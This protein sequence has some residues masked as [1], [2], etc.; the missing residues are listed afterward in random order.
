MT[1]RWPHRSGEAAPRPEWLIVGLGNPG[2]E[3]A[4]TRH[5]V[6]YWT[7]NRLARAHAITVEA[8]GKLAA[9]G[10]GRIEDVPVAL[11]KPRTFVNHSGEAVRELLRRYDLGLDRLLVVSDDL[12]MPVARVRVRQGGRHGGHNGLRSIAGAVGTDFPRVR[13]GIG[14]PVVGG[15]QTWNSEVIADY[16]LRDPPPQ[17]REQLD[18][19][20]GTAIEAI[21][22]I[23]REGVEPAMNQFNRQ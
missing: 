13:I 11:A 17:E 19:A 7:I 10:E 18:E 12:D 1:L 21:E 15:E 23:M 5:N 16:V 14:R 6:G 8:K 3:Y 20:V 22:M 2:S 9:L 4:G